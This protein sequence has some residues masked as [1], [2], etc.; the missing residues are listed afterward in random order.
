MK[1]RSL[2]KI[3]GSGTSGTY[4]SSPLANVYHSVSQ[5]F[6]PSD[7]VRQEKMT[8]LIEELK[9]KEREE[10][11]CVKGELVF[12]DTIRSDGNDSDQTVRNNIQTI[13]R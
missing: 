5:G 6:G 11:K 7:T 8:K 4:F 9:S 10:H 2:K 12:S 13:S 3:S 1:A